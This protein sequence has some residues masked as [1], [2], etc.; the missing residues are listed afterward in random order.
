MNETVFKIFLF[1]FLYLRK[2]YWFNI[3]KYFCFLVISGSFSVFLSLFCFVLF[4]LTS[5]LAIPIPL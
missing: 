5:L 2:L 1:F 4:Y 3:F